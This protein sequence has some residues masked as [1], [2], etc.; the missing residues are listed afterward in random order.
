[1][2][3]CSN[4]LK[5][6]RK[7]SKNFNITSKYFCIFNNTPPANWVAHITRDIVTCYFCSYFSSMV[8]SRFLKLSKMIF[9]ISENYKL[10]SNHKSLFKSTAKNLIIAVAYWS[11][12]FPQK[13]WFQIFKDIYLNI[14]ESS[15]FQRSNQSSVKYV[16]WS[17]L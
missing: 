2:F 17:F 1:M 9:L 4:F 12:I 10:I 7:I 6:P 11:V 5:S 15:Q 14:S 16:R 13:T 3:A 8:A